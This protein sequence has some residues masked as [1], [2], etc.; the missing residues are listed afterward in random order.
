MTSSIHRVLSDFDDSPLVETV[1]GVEFSPLQQWQTPHFGLF[2]H[3]IKAEYPRF[4]VQPPVGNLNVI[5]IGVLEIPVRCWFYDE[6]QTKLIQVQNNRFFYN[7]RN[8]FNK[9]QY[10]RYE[11][12][13][14]VFKTEW[15]RFYNFLIA[16]QFESPQIQ[17]CELSYVNHIEKGKGWESLA[18]LPDVIPYFSGGFSKNF[19]PVPDVI[20]LNVFY[21][22]PDIGGR[23]NIQVQPAIRQDDG[24]E[25]IQLQLSAIGLP[26]SSDIDGM[27]EWFDLAREYIN[28]SFVDFTSPKMHGIWKMREKR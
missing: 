7:W 1:L 20:A 13:K 5:S 14:A 2:W 22:I 4:E 9:T 11:N 27:I 25:I 12:N 15:L 17:H 19:L 16:N 23:I 21:S 26:T 10:P 24:K 8:Y 3:E 28:H 18:D 6:P